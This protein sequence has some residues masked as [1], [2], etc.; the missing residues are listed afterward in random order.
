[1]LRQHTTIT[2]AAVDAAVPRND[3][4]EPRPGNDPPE[5]RPGPPPVPDRA[6]GDI[7]AAVDRAGAR[8]VRT[9]SP[10]LERPPDE[11]GVNPLEGRTQLRL[12]EVAPNH[13]TN[14]RQCFRAGRGLKAVRENASA[15][16]HPHYLPGSSSSS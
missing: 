2:P 1:M 3:P 10:A 5:P 12:V 16:L 8:A 13:P 14:V 11:I 6:A 9:T 15:S 4:P 7:V